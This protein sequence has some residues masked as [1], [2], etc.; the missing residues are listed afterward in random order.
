MA[1]NVLFSRHN[2]EEIKQ[3]YISDCNS[4]LENQVLL[5]HITS[6]EKWNYLFVKNLPPFLR[7]TTS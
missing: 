6:G 3:E 2:N 1:F 5:L 7:E 4:E